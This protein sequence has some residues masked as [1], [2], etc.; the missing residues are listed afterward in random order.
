MK[1]HANI[2]Q[3]QSCLKKLY[4]IKRSRDPL[5]NV[6]VVVTVYILN[7]FIIFLNDIG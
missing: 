2:P 3:L 5:R 4:I 1:K 6:I 7:Y